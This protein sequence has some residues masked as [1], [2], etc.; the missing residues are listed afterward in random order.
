M[1]I[2]FV[3]HGFPGEKEKQKLSVVGSDACQNW[4]DMI[5]LKWILEVVF[6]ELCRETL[7]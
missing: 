7:G 1:E 6:C 5:E 3:R 2:R 4:Y